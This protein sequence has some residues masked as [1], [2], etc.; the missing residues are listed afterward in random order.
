VP[1]TADPDKEI[2]MIAV[3]Y[4]RLGEA[5]EVLEYGRMED[6]QAGPGEVR[7]KLATSAVNPSDVKRRAG[8][9]VQIMEFPRIIPNSDGAGIIDQVGRGVPE[10]RLGER[11]WIYNGQRGRAWGTAAE[12]IAVPA[13]LATP[14]PEGTDF[15][16][17]ATLGIPAMT[18]HRCVF[19]RGPVAGQTILISG[20]AGAVGHY[21]IQLAKWGGA[22][23]LTTV[24]SMAKAEIARDAGADVIIDY[25][26]EAVVDRAMAATAGQGVDLI[27]EVDFGGNL[28]SDLSLI[29]T[30]GTICVY[31]SESVREPKLPAYQLIRKNV[32]LH[33]VLLNNCPAEARRKACAEINAWLKQ[34]LARHLIAGRFSLHQTAQAHRLVESGRKIGTVIVD[35]RGQ[36]ALQTASESAP[37]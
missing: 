8:K 12:Y 17:G 37:Q 26:R 34:G 7:V 29:K 21:A 15:A 32:N 3:W 33:F 5:E 30:N 23:V 1:L 13:D 4:E 28:E 16:Q 36:D 35:I 20:G 6:P 24:S 14:L 9:T 22:T 11:V 18:A 31:A 27:V 2:F 19:I 10:A 25:M